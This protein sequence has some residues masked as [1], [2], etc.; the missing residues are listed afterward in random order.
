LE[1]VLQPTEGNQEGAVE[2]RDGVSGDGGS[3][4]A[5]SAQPAAPA[6]EAKGL[7]GFVC[8]DQGKA[9]PNAKVAVN[10]RPVEVDVQGRFSPKARSSVW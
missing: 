6:I 1:G 2:K 3:V 7:R 8:D 9:V 5:G 4:Q 10:F